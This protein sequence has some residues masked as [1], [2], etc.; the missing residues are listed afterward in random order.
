MSEEHVRGCFP[1]S[2][3]FP[4]RDSVEG[5]ERHLEMV[6]KLC[7]ESDEECENEARKCLAKRSVKKGVAWL[8]GATALCVAREVFLHYCPMEHSF[9]LTF[10]WSGV[11]G[12][13][14]GMGFGELVGPHGGARYWRNE[15]LRRHKVGKEMVQEA[16]RELAEIKARYAKRL[17]AAGS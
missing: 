5:R 17:S 6:R 1:E 12:V 3:F 10:F 4:C 9:I 11:A 15:G 14:Y 13:G 7:A 8:L 2:H 16:E